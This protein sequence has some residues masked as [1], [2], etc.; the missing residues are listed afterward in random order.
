MLTNWSTKD[1]LVE[2]EKWEAKQETKKCIA[3][4]KSNRKTNI[5]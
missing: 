1:N 2:S 5:T 4:V 3:R